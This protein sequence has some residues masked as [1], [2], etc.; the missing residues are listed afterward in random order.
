MLNEAT[1]PAMP[2]TRNIHQHFVP[3]IVFGYHDGVKIPI[4]KKV[5]I[6]MNNPA[7]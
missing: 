1:T 5:H 2:S 7:R 6:P 3:L 4:I